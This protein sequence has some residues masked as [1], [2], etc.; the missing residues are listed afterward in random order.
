MQTHK[1]S[2]VIVSSNAR[3]ILTK[4]LLTLQPEHVYLYVQQ[5]QISTARPPHLNVS[6][7]APVLPMPIP[8]LAVAFPHVLVVNSS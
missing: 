3:N 5:F 6:Q 8:T 4:L 2:I 7:L 1:Q